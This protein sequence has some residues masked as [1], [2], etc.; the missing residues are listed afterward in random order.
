MSAEI[1]L[2][3]AEDESEDETSSPE[4][5]A[6]LTQWRPLP[7]AHAPGP[8]WWG[9]INPVS[10]ATLMTSWIESPGITPAGTRKNDLSNHIYAFAKAA[11]EST[12]CAERYGPGPEVVRAAGR[13]A[14]V[15]PAERADQFGRLLTE[16]ASPLGR[17]VMSFAASAESIRPRG[18]VT[19]DRTRAAVQTACNK[20][21]EVLL[22]GDTTRDPVFSSESSATDTVDVVDTLVQSV[23]TDP[24]HDIS[25]DDA[26]L[27]LSENE[28][29][30]VCW[31]LQWAL[32]QF[33]VHIEDLLLD[34]EEEPGDV[35]VRG[36]TQ[37]EIESA[38][39]ELTTWV[40][41]HSVALL[42]ESKSLAEYRNGMAKR[43]MELIYADPE[44]KA[45]ILGASY[46]IGASYNKDEDDAEESDEADALPDEDE[47]E[48]DT[49]YDEDEADA[50]HDEDEYEM[51]TSYD[52]GEAI[53]LSGMSRTAAISDELE[54]RGSLRGEEASII[55]MDKTVKRIA[56]RARIGLEISDRDLTLCYLGSYYNALRRSYFDG[57]RYDDRNWNPIRLDGDEDSD[58]SDPRITRSEEVTDA[59]P[60][61]L[62]RKFQHSRIESWWE[63]SIRQAPRN[64]NHVD[65]HLIL[66]TAADWIRNGNYVHT[67][68]GFEVALTLE[69]LSKDIGLVT[70]CLTRGPLLTR[71]VH[72]RYQQDQSYDAHGC[73]PDDSVYLIS[74]LLRTV[75]LEIGYDFD[76]DPNA[77]QISSY[78]DD[79]P[80]HF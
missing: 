15:I 49:S 31:S 67:Y 70:D 41:Y 30:L 29:A 20:V 16:M 57:I 48:M 72:Y 46:N 12:W 17:Y 34:I 8:R 4:L 65:W 28:T 25:A 58:L 77:P 62:P 18:R 60:E 13:A 43:L 54:R 11:A 47:Y 1:P 33:V 78:W 2:D 14:A 63:N 36:M 59:P 52:E 21:R 66:D 23:A 32:R 71:E 76:L 80:P 64:N 74:Q 10:R 9:T 22:T 38:L 73:T 7:A 56:L 69:A 61:A 55:A 39:G 24:T 37:T 42:P 27:V 5:R 26:E 35:T 45:T 75:F 19:R 79:L 40:E 6:A 3:L 50:L 51:D 68:G 53:P 44:L